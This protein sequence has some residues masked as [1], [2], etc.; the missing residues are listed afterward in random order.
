MSSAMHRMMFG[1]SV[2]LV[3]EKRTC[4][5]AKAIVPAAAEQRKSLLL[6]IYLLSQAKCDFNVN[7]LELYRK[8]ILMIIIK[9]MKDFVQ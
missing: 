1:V 3:F 9:K 2:S 7:T 5:K 6:T 8:S 4:G